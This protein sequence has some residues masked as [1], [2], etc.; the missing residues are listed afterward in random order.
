MRPHK[1]PGSN[2]PT[3]IDIALEQAERKGFVFAVFGRAVAIGIIAFF[4]LW[5]YYFPIN[6]AVFAATLAV[7][8]TG[9]TALLLVGSRC[10]KVA[11]FAVFTFDPLLI[12]ALLIFAPLSSGGDVP[13]NLVFLTSRVQNYYLVIA[14]AVLTL[15]PVLVI[16]AGFWS[17]VG[18]AS[19]TLYITF[20]MGEY[21][22]FND[23]PRGPSR[24]AFINVVLNPNF[25]GLSSRAQETLI[26]GAVTGITAFAVHRAKL[27]VRAHASAEAGRR[28]VQGLF[29]QY[30]PASVVEELLDEGH[31]APQTRQAT[32]LFADI[33]GFTSIAESMP[34]S[35]LVP[36]L[37]ELFTAISGIVEHQGGIVISYVGDAVIASFN[38]P[39][40][41]DD[42]AARAIEA[43][44]LVLEQVN[45]KQFHGVTIH[46]RIGI[47]TGP[48][49][50]GTVGS[51]GRQTYTVYGDAV[52]LSQR[53]E[54]LNKETGTRCLISGTTIESAK[55]LR[56]IVTSL[57]TVAIR[58]RKQ[59]MEL[60]T[61]KDPDFLAQLK[62]TTPRN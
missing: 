30:V 1:K 29:G 13:Q 33:E 4:A 19:A 32:V 22:T 23:L 25:I 16:W 42:H 59:P 20:G 54:A 3:A 55:S 5:G 21:L 27:V 7:A 24:E 37:T 40:S 62:G 8:L 41:L 51:P 36:L 39:V 35:K 2:S 26:I 60:F 57:G 48:V 6:I 17:I 11:R 50:G 46:V 9:L 44:R 45:G 47:A 56:G 31:L 58:N 49:A 53:L 34:P 43:S 52:N 12:S 38:A 10:E 14:A 61:F 18:L 15:S 28:R